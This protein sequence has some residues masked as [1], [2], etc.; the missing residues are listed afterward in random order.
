VSRPIGS[1]AGILA[2]VM[3]VVHR[4]AWLLW[5]RIF[6]A[7]FSQKLPGNGVVSGIAFGGTVVRVLGLTSAV[8]GLGLGFG[9]WITDLIILH[10]PYKLQKLCALLLKSFLENSKPLFGLPCVIAL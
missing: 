2:V 9:V 8:G 10:C 3:S 5:A 7:F 4:F 1:D 6:W